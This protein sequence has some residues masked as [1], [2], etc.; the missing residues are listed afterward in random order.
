LVM[1]AAP[2][3]TLEDAA[4]WKQFL[5]SPTGQALWCRVRAMEAAAC[6]KACQGEGDPKFSGGMS[7]AFN[8]LEGLA[9]ISVSPAAH[10]ETSEDATLGEGQVPVN[11]ELSYA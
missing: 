9:T 8:W 6:I 1:P 10:G 5:Q 3:W 2:D 7:N 4:R 11:E